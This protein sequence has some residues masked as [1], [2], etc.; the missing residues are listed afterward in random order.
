MPKERKLS[1]REFP[2]S[3]KEGDSRIGKEEVK[4]LA[5]LARMKL[6]NKEIDAFSQQLSQILQYFRKIDEVDTEGIEPTYHVL[7]LTNVFRKDEPRTFP[8]EEVLRNVP[9]KK[10]RYVKA[11]RMG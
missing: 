2:D 3:K 6:S 11:P 5:W 8:A 7:D 10:G 9:E 1:R 4:H